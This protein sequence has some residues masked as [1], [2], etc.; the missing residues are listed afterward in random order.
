MNTYA[1]LSIFIVLVS[2]YE[3][4]NFQHRI[5]V[6]RMFE[7]SFAKLKYESRWG[8]TEQNSY[9]LFCKICNDYY[10][11]HIKEIG[12]ENPNTSCICVR[13]CVEKV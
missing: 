10:I 1:T 6:R 4:L 5:Y 2:K 9:I 13:V 7:T 8:K 11:E 12:P 3:Y